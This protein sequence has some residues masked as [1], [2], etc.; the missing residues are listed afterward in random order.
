MKLQTPAGADQDAAQAAMWFSRAATTIGGIL[1]LMLGV[2]P[3]GCTRST[4]PES[5]QEIDWVAYGRDVLG[6]R[7]LPA[8]GITRENVQQLEVAWTYRTGEVDARFAT[9]K[10][11][12]FQEIGR[13]SCRERV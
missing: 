3:A 10:P 13:A 9:T 8:S 7:Y 4:P 5:K 1:L 11:A 2:L 12:S 6:T